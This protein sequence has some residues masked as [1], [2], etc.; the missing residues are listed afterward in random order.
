MSTQGKSR[1]YS[2]AAL[3]LTFKDL[4]L[5]LVITA[6]LIIV[7]CGESTPEP[8]PALIDTLQAEVDSDGNVHASNKPGLGA[9]IDIELIERNRFAIV[10]QSNI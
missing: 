8:E 1:L 7:A 3:T 5:L 10:F 2:F 4:G 6:T 9:D